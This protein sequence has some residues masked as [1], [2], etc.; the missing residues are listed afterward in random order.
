MWP[1]SANVTRIIG[2]TKEKRTNKGREIYNVDDLSSIPGA[3]NTT[4]LHTPTSQT[5]G[6]HFGDQR[7]R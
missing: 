7:T 3:I 2:K 1:V 6:I 4:I 5:N